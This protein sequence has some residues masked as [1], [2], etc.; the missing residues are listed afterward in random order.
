MSSLPQPD[1]SLFSLLSSHCFPLLILWSI[2]PSP[3]HFYLLML[4]SCS[5]TSSR[6]KSLL[7]KVFSGHPIHN[8]FFLLLLASSAESSVALSFVL[9]YW[10]VSNRRV[11]VY[12]D[13]LKVP[14][15]L[16]RHSLLHGSN[17]SWR[18]EPDV[19]YFEIFLKDKHFQW[20][21]STKSK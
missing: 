16:R 19:Y 6:C 10:Q 21:Y 14:G 7:C 12:L 2:F 17:C 18:Q 8:G 20:F 5:K 13:C 9:R 3:C 4:N 15:T 1:P 11:F